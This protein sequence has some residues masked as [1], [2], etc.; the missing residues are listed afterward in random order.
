[1]CADDNNPHHKRITF[2]S[3]R[4][5]LFTRLP[6]SYLKFMV[7]NRTQQWEIAQAELD[8][9]GTATPN[10][11]I[12]GHAVDRASLNCLS[13]WR[14]TRR[15]GEGLHTWLV[16]MSNEAIAQCHIDRAG[17]YKHEGM[18]FVFESSGAWPILK[19]VMLEKHHRQHEHAREEQDV[20]A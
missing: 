16:R 1:M 2:G 10:L 4:G 6:V 5:E 11:D 8:R 19:T 3:H 17:R 13:I 15:Q 12:S 14:R 18:L 7:C 9:R 20:D